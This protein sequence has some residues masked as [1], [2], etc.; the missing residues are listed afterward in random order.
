MAGSWS[1]PSREAAPG[2]WSSAGSGEEPP[3]SVWVGIKELSSLGGIKVGV[4]YEPPVLEEQIDEAA[5][6][7][8]EETSCSQT[9]LVLMGTTLLCAGRTAQQGMSN[10]GGSGRALMTGS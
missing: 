4:W 3:E 2:T 10:P 8:L 5:C 9:L 1:C 7:Q 6:R